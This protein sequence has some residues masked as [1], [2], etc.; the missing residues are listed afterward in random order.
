ML[1]KNTTY[2]FVSN[3]SEVFT[4]VFV[5]D[6]YEEGICYEIELKP[7]SATFE[8][9]KN[10]HLLF[11]KIPGGFV[12]LADGNFDYTSEVFKEEIFFDFEFNFSNRFMLNFSELNIEPETRYLIEDDFKEEVYLSQIHEI[13]NLSL[14]RPGLAGVFRIKHTLEYPIF[15]IKGFVE[16]E[17]TPREKMVIIKSRAVRLV[18]LC[19]GSLEKFNQFQDSLEITS[20][21]EFVE[22]IKFSDP[23]DIITEIGVDALKFTTTSPL[24]LKS[25][26]NG[27]FKIEGRTLFGMYQ[28]SLPNPHPSTIKFDPI[29]NSFISE[30]YVKL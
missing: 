6:F 23:E 29:S 9:L 10:Y 24:K 20:S 5:H 16:T 27:S 17:F 14:D 18:Y 1:E 2:R 28:K 4:A 26:W 22:Q 8:K 11:K 7:S 19:Y 30:N 12:L 3:Y 15:P 21:G 25:N 13:V